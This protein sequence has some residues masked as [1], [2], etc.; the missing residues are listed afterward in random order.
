MN[1]WKQ[2]THVLK[3]FRA[4]EDPRVR[5]PKDFMTGFLEVGS[6]WFI[7]FLFCPFLFIFPPFSFPCFPFSFFSKDSLAPAVLFASFELTGHQAGN[8]GF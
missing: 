8:V 7:L 6:V 4:E 2:V 1:Y 3:Y 5:L